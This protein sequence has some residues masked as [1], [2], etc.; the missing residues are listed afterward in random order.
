M[1]RQAPRHIL[2]LERPPRRAPWLALA[3]L[4]GG[5]AGAVAAP[6]V[7]VHLDREDLFLGDAVQVTVQVRDAAEIETPDTAAITNCTVTLRGSRNI[8]V[9]RSAWSYN[10]A[11]TVI[12]EYG[13]DFVYEIQPL[14]P[15]RQRLGPWTIRA[16]R[17][18]L[19]VPG[20]EVRVQG[21][22]N[23]DWVRVEINAS[24]DTVLL[25]EAF[26]VDVEISVRALPP[27]YEQHHPLDPQNPPRLTAAFLDVAAIDGLT[28]PDMQ[29][30][31]Q[32]WVEH[33]P[34]SPAFH[35]NNQRFRQ[36]PFGS[37]FGMGSPFAERMARFMF[38]RLTVATPG[39]PRHVYHAR[40]TYVAKREG[41]YTFGPADFR[42][43]VITAVGTGGRI[44]TQPVLAMGKAITIRVAPPPEEGRPES[45]I[46]ALGSNL[47]ATA[48]LDNQTC[49]VGDPLTLTLTLAGDINL[50][51]ARPPRL[52]RQPGFAERFRLYDDT[53]QSDDI[54]GGRT[55]R[56]TLRPLVAGTY[57]LPAV[58]VSYYDARERQYR[59]VHTDP[60]PLRVNEAAQLDTAFILSATT[61]RHD[62]EVSFSSA[63]AQEV[64]AMTM[65]TAGAT[66]ADWF[67]W[68]PHGVVLAAGPAVLGLAA[69]GRALGALRRRRRPRGAN[70][71][72]ALTRAERALHAAGP[73]SHGQLRI[74]LGRY[75]G[76]RFGVSGAGL[77]PTDV[78]Q[79]LVEQTPMSPEQARQFTIFY[80]TVFNSDFTGTPAQAATVPA[81]VRQ[82]ALA[83]LKSIDGAAAPAPATGAHAATPG[84]LLVFAL[85]P[86]AP[87]AADHPRLE[88]RF[89]W[90]HA[91]AQ[92]FNA[93]EPA[94]FRDAAD[95]YGRLAA[96]GVRNG[97]LFFN[98]GLALLKAGDYESAERALLRAER[99]QGTSDALQHNLRL[100]AARGEL[101]LESSLPW[102]RQF[103]FWHY[104][105]AMPLRVMMLLAG[106]SLWFFSFAVRFWRRPVLARELHGV[107]V[108]MLILFGSSVAASWH[109][110]LRDLKHDA[111]AYEA[112]AGS[113]RA[114][115]VEVATP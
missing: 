3:L 109:A 7:E 113:P 60:L 17:E 62:Q 114:T 84:L 1:T 26:E 52:S 11:P 61:N 30:T 76:E 34:G 44:Q 55:F 107:A 35:I 103:L 6:T 25:D 53:V 42:G 45:F 10:A 51:Q 57:E 102:Y 67:A 13:R 27:P 97:P 83:W 65:S 94:A 28:G 112:S 12:R 90:D 16:D 72:H 108:V 63:A 71:R 15:G 19:N 59:T 2:N 85:L 89:R 80:T 58:A 31:L 70:P 24:R 43:A 41:S 48:T 9:S 22:E 88:H 56:Y 101:P 38:P 81:T 37:L 104:R 47:V 46:G 66:P 92:M 20:P 68:R 5:T 8:N 50:E 91:N 110:E 49:S 29:T 39:G 36:D 33:N 23:Q 98:Q 74:L 99:Y 87:A 93:I 73:L 86:L 75:L 14:A 105:L 82:E 78:A 79:L 115:P 106:V 111:L 4:L 96:D 32:G 64:A 77:G 100:A 40:L 95:D 69:L 54:A 21:S 18:L